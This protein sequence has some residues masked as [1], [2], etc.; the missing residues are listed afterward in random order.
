MIV[1]STVELVAYIISGLAY[2]SFKGKSTIKVFVMSYII[3]LVGA[4][5]ILINDKEKL[6][7]MD[8][9]C[10]FIVKIGTASSY[11]GVYI[12]NVLFPVVFASTTFG[13]CC[14]QGA[15]A[16]MISPSVYELGDTIPWYI[17]IALSVLGIIC[18][19]SLRDKS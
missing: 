12:A 19:I 8:M 2:D 1:I 6:P 15:I 14:M 17:F 18:S 5:G 13:I 7:Y 11:Q 4:I 9:I 16:S 10:N 3:C